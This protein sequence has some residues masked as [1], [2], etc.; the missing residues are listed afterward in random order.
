M[1]RGGF[2]KFMI[3]TG[4]MDAVAPQQSAITHVWYGPLIGQ[5]HCHR[6]GEAKMSEHIVTGLR[7]IGGMEAQAVAGRADVAVVA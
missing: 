3:V 4:G 6:G 1:P 2:K 7:V 5:S